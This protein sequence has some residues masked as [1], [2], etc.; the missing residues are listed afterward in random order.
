MEPAAPILLQSLLRAGPAIGRS[1]DETN[2]CLSAVA[3]IE[4]WS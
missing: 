4:L 2:R 1:R 3:G